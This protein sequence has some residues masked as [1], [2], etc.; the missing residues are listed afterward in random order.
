MLLIDSRIVPNIYLKV[1]ET[2]RLIAL[3][4][5]KNATEAVKMT[6]ISR[7]A[8]YKYK[9][10]V[11][12]Y[13]SALGKIVTFQGVLSDT[14]GVLSGLLTKLYQFGA[15]ILTVNQDLPTEGKASFT[16]T[17]ACENVAENIDLYDKISR[18]DGVMSLSQVIG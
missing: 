5:A 2:K 4:I 17:V 9:D 16:I 3:G 15:N 7:S 10:Y 13:N 14:P 8:F 12:Q 6:G 1:I 11:S 18:L